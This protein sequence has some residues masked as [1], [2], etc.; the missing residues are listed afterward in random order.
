MAGYIGKARSIAIPNVDIGSLTEPL[1]L[2]SYT[3][4][5]RDALTGLSAGD[6]IYNTTTASIQ[7]YN[8]VD[9]STTNPAPIIRSITGIIQEGSASTLT[10]SIIH[11]TETIDVKY[12]EGATLLATDSSVTVTGDSATS[13]V[14]SAVYGQT[15]GDTITISIENSTGI[16]SS[17]S[18]DKTVTPVPTGGTITTVGSYRIHTFTSSSSF[19]VPSGLSLT[20]VEYVVIAGGG[21]AGNDAGAGEGTGGGGAGGYRS[22]VSNEFSGGGV[23]AESKLSLSPGSYTVTIG[24]GGAAGGFNSGSNT[25]F[26]TITATGGGYGGAWN[27]STHVNGA[28]GGSGG[29]GNYSSNGGSGTAGQGYAGGSST[30][31][32]PFQGAGGGGAGAAG[33]G[34]GNP[35]GVGGDG[36]QSSINGTATYRAGGGGGGA[37]GSSSSTLGNGGA[38]GGGD[39]ADN[40]SLA[41]NGTANTGGGGGGGSVSNGDAD[42]GSGGSGI[43]IVRYQL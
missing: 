36:V 16:P 38:G 41:Q 29:G 35:L 40:D 18:I 19:V 20:D 30:W 31:A 2:K 28:S 32:S 9:W 17:N 15:A 37:G 24:A 39:G 5:Q 8:G 27:G 6:T 14:P 42:G 26:G 12:Y 13:T 34:G 11:A 4:A 10:L 23:N 3:T 25:T 1:G 7:F 43:V 21:S 22:S 33:T